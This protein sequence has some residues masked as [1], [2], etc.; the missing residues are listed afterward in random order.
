MITTISF[1]S[2]L[3][4]DAELR[5]REGLLSLVFYNH[6]IL[7]RATTTKDGR[8]RRNDKRAVVGR[9]A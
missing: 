8:D 9:N 7:G 3:H 6:R 5:T 1:I 4:D 2:L